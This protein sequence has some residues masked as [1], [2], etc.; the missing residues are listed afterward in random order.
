MVLMASLGMDYFLNCDYRS[1][2]KAKAPELLKDA[3]E[4]APSPVNRKW[5]ITPSLFSS[6]SLTQFSGPPVRN[7]R[8]SH[9]QTNHQGYKNGH[10]YS[11]EAA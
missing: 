10:I 4:T 8:R 5:P 9:P 2:G 11:Q 1:R 3:L 7:Y 6:L